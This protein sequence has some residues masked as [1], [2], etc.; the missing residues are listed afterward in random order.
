M[1]NITTADM[2]IIQGALAVTKYKKDSEMT[3]NI[4]I[5]LQAYF[6][7]QQAE[8]S[9]IQRYKQAIIQDTLTTY[10]EEKAAREAHKRA[11]KAL[12][13]LDK[14]TREALSA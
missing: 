9:A 11:C 12:S 5:N 3:D 8:D 1:I 14:L 7:A 6:S 4:I 10:D 13:E 2:L